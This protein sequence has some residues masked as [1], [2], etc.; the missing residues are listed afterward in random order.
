MA[1][2]AGDL[3]DL[4]D[5]VHDLGHLELEQL[6]DEVGVR[7]RADDL[8]PP[9]RAADLHDVGL[10]PGAV[11]VAL[12]RH[13]LRLRQERLDALAEV[14][15]HVAR[16][17]LLDDRRDDVALPARILAVG[18]LAL[19]L[20]D[21]LQDDLL[22]GL[23][24]DAAEVGRRLLPPLLDQ[25]ELAGL[26]VLLH[27]LGE[28]GDVAALAV[29]LDPRVVPRSNGRTLVGGSER[30]LERRHHAFE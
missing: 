7:A 13:L 1:G 28:H 25:L 24:G 18:D 30:L 20:P 29:D 4:D 2:L 8:R 15:Q 16:V 3:L 22:G 19:R 23:G 12:P 14:E 5:A 27:L 6:L 11:V 26:L 10:H 21:P 17:G 9:R